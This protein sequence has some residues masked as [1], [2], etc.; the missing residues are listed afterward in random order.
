MARFA[1]IVIPERPHH[2][3][4]RGDPKSRKQ[5]AA[6]RKALKYNDSR[7]LLCP[8]MPTQG[9]DISSAASL[10]STRRTFASLYFRMAVPSAPARANAGAGRRL[11]GPAN[12]PN[13]FPSPQIA[14]SNQRCAYGLSL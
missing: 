2:V 8:L 12:P 1:R 10:I 9:R 5:P 11:P 13:P 6:P 7:P 14:F 3:T 4:E